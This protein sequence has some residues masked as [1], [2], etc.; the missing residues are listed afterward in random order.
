M[1]NFLAI[2]LMLVSLL[3]W[4]QDPIFYSTDHMRLYNNPAF[5]GL[6]KSFS[7]DIGYRHQW[8]NI[9]GDYVTS[10]TSVNQYL[11]KGNG[12]SL[13][14]FTDNA[15]DVIYKREILFGYAKSFKIHEGHFL[16]IGVQSSYYQKHFD[17]DHLTF[18]DMIDPRRG[19]VYPTNEIPYVD[20]ANFDFHAGLIYQN[21]FFY[22]GF[23]TKHLLRPIESFYDGNNRVPI[24]YFGEMGG[25]I[26]LGED[27]N[28]IPHIQYRI[29]DG[30]YAFLGGAKVK[31]RKLYLDGG[32][33]DSKTFYTAFGFQSEHFQCSYDLVTYRWFTNN[34]TYFAHEFILGV[35]LTLFKKENENFFDF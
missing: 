9:T 11:G 19:F 18:G 12:V 25:K 17:F 34:E 10:V 24:L 30:F 23:S 3:G 27:W 28:I 14:F 32:I 2:T 13:Q 26:D 31:W 20:M 5:S 1:K 16:S 15:G 7:F 22:T 29:Q 35:D 6:N 21:E 33:Q 8:P 4:S